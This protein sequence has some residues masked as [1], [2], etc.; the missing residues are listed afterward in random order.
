MS[1]T[2]LTLNPSAPGSSGNVF[3]P[4][5]Q[6]GAQ[7]AAALSLTAT[8][9]ALQLTNVSID[10]SSMPDNPFS[11]HGLD[12]GDW[13]VAD[14]NLDFSIWFAP[15]QLL[16]YSATLYLTFDTGQVFSFLLSG[17][18]LA[19]SGGGEGVPVPAA[20]MLLL[21]GLLGAAALRR[22]KAS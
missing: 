16:T 2:A 9:G 8:S 19:A 1:I 15:L 11:L 20:A 12:I 6:I 7:S 17:D 22:R 14:G 4:A 10:F 21:P 3:L 5:T 13:V 18:A